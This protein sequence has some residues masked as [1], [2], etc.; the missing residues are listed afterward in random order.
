MIGDLALP[1]CALIIAS[2]EPRV[3]L[4]NM[5]CSAQPVN[6]TGGSVGIPIGH[7]RYCCPSMVFSLLCCS[8]SDDNFASIAAAVKEGR[9]VYNNVE[10]AMLFM[11][12]T[13]VA[14]ASVI[15]VAILFGFAMPI[16]APQI[17][18][19]QHGHVR[20]PRP[21]DFVRATRE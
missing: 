6:K 16:T 7:T 8:A 17:S 14:E 4:E 1:D 19:G 12:P 5:L 10:K 11:L 15:A 13:N 21:G 20:G 18:L 9:T 2:T 3:V